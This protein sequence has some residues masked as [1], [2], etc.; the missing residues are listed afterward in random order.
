MNLKQLM[1]LVSP[2]PEKTVHTLAFE[3]RRITYTF[4]LNK[5]IF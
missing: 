4:S 3:A 2:V 1:N 5:N